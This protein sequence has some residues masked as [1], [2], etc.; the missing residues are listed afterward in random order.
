MSLQRPV[1]IHALLLLALLAVSPLAAQETA[2]PQ[3]TIHVNGSGT[4]FGT[5][6]IAYIEIGFE[7]ADE[8]LNYAFEQTSTTLYAIR[9][10]MLALDIASEDI[11]T[12]GL[13]L[14]VDE[15]YMDYDQEPQRLYRLSNT[16]RLVIRDI[17]RVADAID[18]GVQAGANNIYGLQYGI[19]N[20]QSLEDLARARAAA[21]AKARA[22]N[23]A[24]LFGKAVGEPIH[25]SDSTNVNY[26]SGSAR[27]HAGLDAAVAESGG[28]GPI[29]AGQFSVTVN[30][31]VT[32]ELRPGEEGE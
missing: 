13:S 27:G 19:S 28:G 10:A 29:E 26:G 3:N 15:R 30:L 22:A 4:V 17:E 16:F 1:L 5:P 11:Q 23:L 31:S 14:W 21:D 32:F 7:I 6:D 18:A 8:D 20:T 25:I 12:R 9:D 2:N 24:A